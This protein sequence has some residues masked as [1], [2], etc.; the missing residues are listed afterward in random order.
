LDADE[1]TAAQRTVPAISGR[2]AMRQITA[3]SGHS[4]VEPE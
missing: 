1:V 2:S 3:K 4:T